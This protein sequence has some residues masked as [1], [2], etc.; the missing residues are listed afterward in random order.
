MK[1]KGFTLTEMMGVIVILAILVIIAV[2]TYF[3]IVDTVKENNLNSKLN[4]IE[5]KAIEYA[6]NLELDPGTITVAKLINEGYLEQDSKL[7]INSQDNFFK[8]IVNPKGGFLD[9]YKI[10]I[11]F[12]NNEYHAE[13]VKNEED[14]EAACEL[15]YSDLASNN[16]KVYAY[17]ITNRDT[18]TLGTNPVSIKDYDSSDNNKVEWTN[19]D[20][21]LHVSLNNI[22]LDSNK[23]VRYIG[24]GITKT[25]E[26]INWAASPTLVSSDTEFNSIANEYQISGTNGLFDAV[27]DT[28][29]KVVLFTTTNQILTQTIPIKID[30]EKPTFTY[31]IDRK[32]TGKTAD[33]KE[34]KPVTFYLSD[35][36][37]SGVN[38]LFFEKYSASSIHNSD[39]IIRLCTRGDSRCTKITDADESKKDLTL[40]DGDWI[41]YIVDKVG[42]V[43]KAQLIRVSNIDGDTP[44]C[45]TEPVTVTPEKTGTDPVWYSASDR[46]TAYFSCNQERSKSGC[47]AKDAKYNG[48]VITSTVG[49]MLEL[50]EGRYNGSVS[51]KVVNMAG[52]ENDCFGMLELNVD[53]TPPVCGQASTKVKL[54]TKEVPDTDATTTTPSSS[55]GVGSYSSYSGYSGRPYTSSSTGTTKMKTVTEEESS[56]Y[57]GEWTNLDYVYLLI[58]C[59]S[60]PN[61]KDGTKGSGCSSTSSVDTSVAT[62]V[63]EEGITSIPKSAT[64]S[65]IA[66]NITKCDNNLEAKIDRTAPVCDYATGWT[67]WTKEDRTINWGGHDVV[68]SG[69]TLTENEISKV[70]SEYQQSYTYTTSTSY[71]TIDEYTI[72]DNAGN[73]TKCESKTI[74][75]LVDK[76]DPYCTSS[77]VWSN[78]TSGY[79]AYYGG[80]DSH[81]GINSSVSGSGSVFVASPGAN[82]CVNKTYG[83]PEYMIYDNVGHSK[84]CEARSDTIKF[85]T[86]APTATGITITSKTAAYNSRKVE[87]KVTGTDSCSYIAAACVTKTNDAS[88]CTWYSAF[89]GGYTWTSYDI[90]D[91]EGTGTT[92]TLYGFVKDAAGNISPTSVSATYTVYAYC[93]EHIMKDGYTC[94]AKC[95]GGTKNQL[96]YDKHFT[97]QRCDQFDVSSGG[98]E[99]NKQ[100][101]CSKVTLDDWG[102]CKCP[103]YQ[104]RKAWSYYDS[105]IRCKSKDLKANNLTGD[106]YKLKKSCTASGCD[107]SSGGSSGGEAKCYQPNYSWDDN[108]GGGGPCTPTQEFEGCGEC[109]CG[110]S[111]CNG[112]SAG[113]DY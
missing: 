2:P 43:S 109:T 9:C 111:G 73:E 5:S 26:V 11:T 17:E 37:G 33:G 87:V 106:N 96:G 19:K 30:Q 14:G 95:D 102:K 77:N 41:V 79:T 10:H 99:C 107:T 23:P 100:K 70:P 22:T 74:N 86:Q 12:E 112:C 69:S 46:A 1:N 63:T 18:N 16:V 91:S 98:S 81:S 40:E 45:G 57:N 78:D 34:A 104:T 103:G 61:L 15:A 64:I 94:T 54:V 72:K 32:W 24:G 75:I 113:V 51:W 47:M 84:K 85:D 38:Y 42:N 66:G 105:T 88:T 27:I 31:T 39:E 71:D 108:C 56:P 59:G 8:Q 68:P 13:V 50:D 52:T 92:H 89:S 4:Y 25:K 62:K 90:D 28:T 65:D 44:A 82:A 21:L 110:S 80:R 58:G 60:D 29:F 49:S 3:K 76:D 93:T 7:D 53:K 97:N 35:G 6:N 20:T 36:K 83:I 67:T 101:C 55:S 48:R